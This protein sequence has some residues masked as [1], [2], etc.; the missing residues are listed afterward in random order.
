M[1]T[2]PYV[3]NTPLEEYIELDKTLKGVGVFCWRGRRH[4]WRKPGAQS[5][6]LEHGACSAIS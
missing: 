4:G 6:C 3:T 2:I 5:A 1:S